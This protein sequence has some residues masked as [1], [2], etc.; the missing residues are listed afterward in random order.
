MI[1][2]NQLK[3][4]RTHTEKDLIRQCAK[5]LRTE[6]RSVKEISII[7]KSLDAR[8]KPELFWVYIVDVKADDEKKILKRNKSRDIGPAPDNRYRMPMAGSEKLEER[9]VIVGAGPCGLFC[10][11]LLAVKGYRPI[12]IERGKPVDQRLRDV[13][14]F[15]KT[16][17]L[18][19]N[20]NVQF[21]EGGAGTFS[22][23]KLNT[24]V[25]DNAGRNY[26][27][28]KVFVKMGA[29]EE[30]LYQH[31]PHLG[32]DR[33]VSIV[34]KLRE[35]IRS[36]G[37][38]FLFSTKMTDLV[39]QDGKIVQIVLDDTRV[40]KTQVLITAIG[41]SARDTMEMFYKR[42][43]PMEA[44][45]FA[46]GYRVEHPQ[47][48]INKNQYGEEDPADL[49]AASYKVTASAQ[50]DRGVYSFCMC[51]G[52]FVVNASSEEGRLAVNGMSNSDRSEKNANSAI[53]MAIRPEDYADYASDTIPACLSGM[54]FQRDMERRAYEI[55]KG[56]IP[57]QRFGDYQ[58]DRMTESLGDITPSI[59]GAWTFG[60]V[61]SILPE[62]L[63]QAFL[64]GME[65]FAGKIPGFADPDVLVEGLESRTSSPVRIPRNKEFLCEK[66]EGFY[67]A[68][69]GAGYAGGIMSAAMDGLRIAESVITRYSFENIKD[70]LSIQEI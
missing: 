55:G 11:Y 30:I 67:P 50:E 51:P 13:E 12:I 33:L 44:K 52:G 58:A 57:V 16:G 62:I 4:P 66:I 49:S 39:V 2:I 38:E 43:I 37:G 61:R 32:T 29:E 1:R 7:R 46:V 35:E 69:E 26:F 6:E 23:G 63:V 9:P 42:G 53:V 17:E 10:A 8:K 47:A 20:S 36:L 54:A 64:T 40:L 60:N 65:N 59:K 18:D 41:H 15:W 19:P 22:D 25:K 21:G 5:L 56:K 28:R 48:L 14:H 70:S 34:Q 45:P 31:Q 3:M 68:G 27:V 24:M